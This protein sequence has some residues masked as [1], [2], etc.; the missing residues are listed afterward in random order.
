MAIFNVNESSLS[1]YLNEHGGAHNKYVKMI[2][3]KDKKLKNREEAFRNIGTDAANEKADKA[4]RE[5]NKLANNNLK[6]IDDYGNDYISNVY[7]KKKEDEKSGKTVNYIQKN[8]RTSYA[9]GKK[10]FKRDFGGKSKDTTN[11][12]DRKPGTYLA[13][14]KKLREA[15]EYILTVLDESEKKIDNKEL[16]NAFKNVVKSKAKE[17]FNKGKVVDIDSLPDNNDNY[18]KDKIKNKL[19]K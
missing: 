5:R 19:N 2:A 15:A 11:T 9:E 4:T 13:A 12:N 17:L 8:Q 6:Y 3:D 16:N 1:E 18:I 14:Q 10:R 7:K